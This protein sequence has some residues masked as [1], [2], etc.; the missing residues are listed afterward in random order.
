[1]RIGD[2][3]LDVYHPFI[4]D[5]VNG[6]R[7]LTEVFAELGY[8]LPNLEPASATS[9]SDDGTVVAGVGVSVFRIPA[10]DN[11]T[12]AWL[13]VLPAFVPVPEPSADML[14]LTSVAV[15]TGLGRARR[16]TPLRSAAPSA[17]CTRRRLQAW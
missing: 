16:S 8:T 5:A 3:G 1:V 7:D 14:L 10:G 2:A 13:G 4:W 15:L 12:E 17:P 6:M 11:R 9:I